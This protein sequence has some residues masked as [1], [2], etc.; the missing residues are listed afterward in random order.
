M[1]L[2]R[3]NFPVF[4]GGLDDLSD[5]VVRGDLKL[6]TKASSRFDDV[7]AIW[8]GEGLYYSSLSNAAKLTIT[9]EDTD[10]DGLFGFAVKLILYHPSGDG[11]IVATLSRE[12][13]SRSM[14]FRVGVTDLEETR[15]Y[16]ASRG[17]VSGRKAVIEVK[18][19][20]RMYLNRYLLGTSE[21]FTFSSTEPGARHCFIFKSVYRPPESIFRS[22]NLKITPLLNKVNI[23]FAKDHR[24]PAD[25]VLVKTRLENNYVDNNCFS[26][27]AVARPVT[28]AKE[29]PLTSTPPPAAPEIED[30][31]A[32][33]PNAISV[34]EAAEGLLDVDAVLDKDPNSAKLYTDQ[35]TDIALEYFVPPGFMARSDARVV[36]ENLL[37]YFKGLYRSK[38][39]MFDAAV[40]A[41]LV[42]G[43]L[44]YSTSHYSSNQF[45]NQPVTLYSGSE[46]IE[47]DFSDLKKIIASSVDGV[48]YSNPVRQ[49][50]RWFSPT[51]VQLIKLGKVTPNY[52]VQAKHGVV[53]NFIPYCFDFCVLDSRYNTKDEKISNALSRAQAVRLSG[54]RNKYKAELHNTSELAGL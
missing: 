26:W 27:E 9:V 31:R 47:V 36:T 15:Y 22:S 41:V 8:V 48:G 4:D 46:K 7:G 19:G 44:T 40:V 21:K 49:Y 42:Q 23:S 25:G 2:S 34:E 32:L 37:N 51:A 16:P 20:A 52:A 50:M 1:D 18:S 17:T 14:V 11:A 6:D 45:Q 30:S 5:L 13:G 3:C 29:L 39:L 33:D 53:K 38:N 43:A 35:M 10:A 24:K 12:E 28:P 54:M